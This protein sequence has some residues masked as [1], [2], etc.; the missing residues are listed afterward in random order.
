MPWWLRLEGVCAEAT[1][2]WEERGYEKLGILFYL[3][4]GG[5]TDFQIEPQADMGEPGATGFY[6][7]PLGAI[8]KVKF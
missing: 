6:L 7:P 3:C 8:G 5:R 1:E 2:G 4:L